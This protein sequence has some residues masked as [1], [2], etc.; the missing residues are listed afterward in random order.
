MEVGIGFVVA[1]QD[2]EFWAVFFDQG[3]FKN[4]GIEFAPCN[5]RFNIVDTIH[6]FLN[7]ERGRPSFLKVGS[8]PVLKIFGFPY[9]ENIS[10]RI[11]HQIDSGSFGEMQKFFSEGEGEAIRMILHFLHLFGLKL[12]VTDIVGNEGSN[13]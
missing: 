6:H 4:Q 10:L 2:V 1:E 13:V 11:F 5:Q 9:I 8:D 3:V 12:C 7:P